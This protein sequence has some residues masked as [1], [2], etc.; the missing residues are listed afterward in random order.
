MCAYFLLANYVMCFYVTFCRMPLSF[1]LTQREMCIKILLS[2]YFISF[3]GSFTRV[4]YEASKW[5]MNMVRYYVMTVIDMSC[6]AVFLGGN[7]WHRAILAI[8][9]YVAFWTRHYMC[10]LCLRLFYYIIVFSF[11]VVIGF[12]S[13]DVLLID[14]NTQWRK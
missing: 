8:Y 7:G 14:R 10:F 6:F 13:H 3:D 5:E 12:S 9:D 2:N 4:S 1:I 11:G